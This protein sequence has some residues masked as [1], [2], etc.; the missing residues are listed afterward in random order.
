MDSTFLVGGSLSRTSISSICRCDLTS[1]WL[2][3]WRFSSSSSRRDDI[4]SRMAGRDIQEQRSCSMSPSSFWRRRSGSGRGNCC[5]SVPKNPPA[6]RFP[7]SDAMD[8][9]LLGI[10]VFAIA[11]GALDPRGRQFRTA[12]STHSCASAS[13]SRPVRRRFSPSSLDDDWQ[14]EH[15][16]R[17]IEILVSARIF[18]TQAKSIFVVSVCLSSSCFSRADLFDRRSM[19]SITSAV[20]L[21]GV[22]RCC[23]WRSG[24]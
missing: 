24:P 22:R 19:A 5:Y 3:C 16:G 11:F 7:T 23:G 8:P 20:I 1:F 6:S 18:R 21:F 14:T 13:S 2:E 17:R 12:N 15:A 4:V 9:S 10:C